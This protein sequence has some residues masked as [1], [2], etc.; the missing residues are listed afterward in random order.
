MLS[1]NIVIQLS[2]ELGSVWVVANLDKREAKAVLRDLVTVKT[3][4]PVDD[5]AFYVVGY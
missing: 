4:S 2:Q 1:A 3:T 5:D